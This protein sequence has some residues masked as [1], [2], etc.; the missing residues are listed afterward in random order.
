MATK[1]EQ[2]KKAAKA[3]AKGGVKRAAKRGGRRGMPA[4]DV[5]AGPG[6][7]R[8]KSR[9]RKNAVTRTR[10]NKSVGGGGRGGGR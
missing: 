9:R 1:D 10:V 7:R 6:G 2:K 8:T 3:A 5:K 4:S